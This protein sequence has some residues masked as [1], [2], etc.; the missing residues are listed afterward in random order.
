[1]AGPG[2]RRWLCATTGGVPERASVGA[3]E[4]PLP[5]P[6]KSLAS[7]ARQSDHALSLSTLE[8]SVSRC[9]QDLLC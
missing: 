4:R 9:D 1:M 7:V 3:G 5:L 6:A 2:Y 8:L